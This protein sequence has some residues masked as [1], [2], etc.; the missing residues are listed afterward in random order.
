[1][2]TFIIIVIII[3]PTKNKSYN[4]GNGKIQQ[5]DICGGSESEQIQEWLYWS[6]GWRWIWQNPEHFDKG[7][8][9]NPLTPK[10]QYSKNTHVICNTRYKPTIC[11][12]HLRYSL[13]AITRQVAR[14]PSTPTF[15][16]KLQPI[17]RFSISIAMPKL[18]CTLCLNLLMESQKQRLIKFQTK[19]CVFPLFLQI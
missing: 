3:Q 14:L 8:S 5:V 18:Y 9:R 15:T 4:V 2:A 16:Q 11:K 13:F 7:F 17:S 12:T 19:F 1:M 6:F 10:Y